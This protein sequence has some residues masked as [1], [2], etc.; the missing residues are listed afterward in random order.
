MIV[1]MSYNMRGKDAGALPRQPRLTHQPTIHMPDRAPDYL[2]YLDTLQRLLEIPATDLEVALTQ[3][4]DTLASV[5]AADKVDAFLFDASRD[6]LVA[7]GTSTQPLSAL[8][9]QL[10]LDVL[11]LSNGGRSVDVFRSGQVYT[12]GNVLADEGEVRGIK[13]GLRI[14]SIVAAPLDAGE[15]RR[16]VLLVSSLQPDF[17]TVLDARLVT[18]A[19]RWI[20]SV[21]ERAELVDSIRRAAVEQARRSTGDELVS[22]VAHDIRN[23]LQPITWRLHALAH[24]A[25]AAHRDDDVADV[26]ATQDILAQL[27]SLVSNLLDSARL[28]SG[29]DD[30]QLEALDLATLANEAAAGAASPEHAID[31]Q[32][33]QPVMV[34]GERVRLRQCMDNVLANALAHSPD[35][36]PV[37]VYVSRENAADRVWAKLEIID[38]GA[39]I[40]ESILP[41]VFEKFLSA[42]TEGRGLGLG[43]YIAKRIASAH[44]GDLVADRYVGK[45]ARFTLRIP[46][47]P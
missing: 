7:V 9:R 11:P 34:A 5:L 42:G 37:H 43:L 6:S 39:G 23:Y 32:A 18:S 38:E 1:D 12:C 19:A 2:R 13:E 45:G 26:R 25:R 41:H 14:Q 44:H 28:E 33:A 3:A 24:R 29:L 27:A 21:A 31:V 35:N 47:L 46:A 22:I 40:P 16:G 30:L 15:R 10:G 4:A 20:A 36:A 17:F 8:E